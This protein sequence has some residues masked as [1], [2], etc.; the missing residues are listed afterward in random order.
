MKLKRI[1][2]AD[3]TKVTAIRVLHLSP[4]WHVSPRVLEKGL[5]EGWLSVA[6]ARLTLHTETD[7][8]DVVYDILAPPDRKQGR[9]YYDCK[10]VQNG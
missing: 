4:V 6:D 8:D 2:N 1:F 10:V 5:A 7:T 3:Q 9:N